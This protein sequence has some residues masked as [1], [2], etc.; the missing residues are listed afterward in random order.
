M[1]GNGGKLEIRESY[2]KDDREGKIRETKP[3][4]EEV[5]WGGGV[6]VVK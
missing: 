3:Q 5:D 1:T 4:V 2:S 6:E